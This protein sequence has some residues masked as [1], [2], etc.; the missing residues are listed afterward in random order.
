MFSSL[1]KLLRCVKQVRILSA[2][3]SNFYIDDLIKECAEAGVGTMFIEII[4][5]IL[6]FCDDI[7]LLSPTIDDLQKLLIICGN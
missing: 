7:G 4:M 3:L 5:C 2:A 6:G 1:F